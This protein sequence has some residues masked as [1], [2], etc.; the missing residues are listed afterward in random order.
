MQRPGRRALELV[1]AR[2]IPVAMLKR[3]LSPF[4][5][6][7]YAVLRFIAGFMFSFHGVQKL[8]GVL[9]DHAR[10]PVGSQAWLGGVIE[11]ACGVAIALGVWTRAAAFLA[12]GTMAVEYVQFHWKGAVDSRFLPIVN[13]GELAVLYCFLYLYVACR[14]GGRWS[15]DGRGRG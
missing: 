5:E 8:F 10:P 6:V 14:G 2:A 7:A 3:A 11:L 12:S 4:D 9:T 1:R 13:G 15:V